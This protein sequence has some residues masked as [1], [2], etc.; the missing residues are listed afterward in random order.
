LPLVAAGAGGVLVL[1]LAVVA[2][3]FLF[4]DSVSGPWKEFAPTDGGFSVLLPTVPDQKDASD[5]KLVTASK[6]REHVAQSRK[7]SYTVQYFDLPEK[8]YNNYVYFGWYRNHLLS[9]GGKLAREQDVSQDSYAGKE[10]T[11]VDLPDDQVLVRRMYL[12]EARVFW[13]TA[14]YP[15]S[16]PAE[17]QKFFD[18]FKI[19]SVAKA[20]SSQ[21][22]VAEG[23]KP[24]E[25]PPPTP[26]TRPDP[27]MPT[28]APPVTTRP[29]DPPV[30]V[31]P[32][33]QPM[34]MPQPMPPVAFAISADEQAMLDAINRLRQGE[35]V[36]PLAA[37]QAMFESARAV[38]TAIAQGMQPPQIAGR[39]YQV[40]SVNT[41]PARGLTAQQ[42][43]D[44]HTKSKA[45]KAALA[46]DEVQ[47]IGVGVAMKDGVTI[48]IVYMAGNRK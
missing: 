7:A 33:P 38:A 8:P 12:A 27:P 36:P 22:L 23:P 45:D 32:P 28:P 18:S 39:G 34:P 31:V 13:L 17:A 19:T 6:I 37:Q 1:A 24:P 16:A 25:P 5:A 20:K 44:L 3:F 26:S 14:R 43:V 10:V 9:G 42:L 48:Y 40:N 41:W 11:V 29:A 47:F 35:K 4:G 21:P 15:R 2:A 30:V 46:D